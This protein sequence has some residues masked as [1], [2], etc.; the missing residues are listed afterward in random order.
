MKLFAENIRTR[1]T[2]KYIGVFALL[3]F[4]YGV[5]TTIFLYYYLSHQLDLNLKED[6]EIIEEL[7]VTSD[8]IVDPAT[9]NKE[10]PPKRY[11]RFVE[12]WDDSS[13]LLYRSS[14][15]DE[16]LK[17]PP[18][19]VEQYS[20]EPRYFSV[21]LPNGQ[22]WRM[23]GVELRLHEQRR[24]LR[25]SM[26]GDHIVEQMREFF[27]FMSFLAP[28]FLLIGAISGYILAR[29]ALV[30]ID[31]MVIQ[32]KK[33]GAEN[34]KERLP[35]INPK[36]ELGNLATVTNELLDRIQHSFEQLKSFT[37]DASH[38]LRTPLTVMRSV[39]EVGLQ[40][41]HTID[42]LREVVG[43]MLEENSRLTRLV[44]CLLLLSR[45]D[46]GRIQLNKEQFDLY[47]FTNETT[48]VITILAEEK[49]Q[50]LSVLGES[51]IIVN[52]DKTLLRQA[53]LNLLDN[54]IKYSPP[55]GTI[56]VTVS[57][58]PQ[59]R[60]CIEV[61]DSGPGISQEHHGKVFDRFYRIDKDRSRE[62]GG[63]G[64]GLAI[65][66]WVMSIHQGTVT[67]QSSSAGSMFT[68]ELPIA[69]APLSVKTI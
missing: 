6:I 35:V 42:D 5:V 46:S 39:G 55:K 54:A 31:R 8:V 59:R 58:T 22:Q 11:E 50:T 61:K 7:L 4:G 49:E 30:P 14:A 21:T 53:L 41:A 69:Q 32:A 60:S 64:L 26:S 67:L 47:R 45:A 23:I 28:F 27:V 25:I 68:L 19:S 16:T 9:Q 37:S 15:F 48:E 13:H 40:S 36:D 52:A 63:A 43:S 57:Q 44:D 38:E 29:Q 3:L 2:L 17:F 1:L 66:Q 65:V 10:H 12:I 18:P 24:I 20:D 62:T 56:V 33:I 51:G 34:L